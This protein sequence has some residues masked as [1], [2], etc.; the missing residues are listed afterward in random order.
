[1]DTD[2]KSLANEMVGWL[3]RCPPSVG[4]EASPDPTFL[5]KYA[6]HF[7]APRSLLVRQ[8]ML[9]SGI[10][11]EQE[12]AILDFGYLSGLTQEFIHRTFPKAKF[13]VYDHPD[14]PIFRDSNYLQTIKAM[15]Y[16]ELL[17]SDVT[18]IQEI[19]ES[20]DV[21]ILG[22]IIEHLDPT[23][24]ANLLKILRRAAKP[25]ALL[26]VTTPNA[27]GLYN[28][29]M[30]LTGKQRVQVAPIPD[31]VH[32]Y[33]HIHLW[34]P[35]LL[36]QTAQHYGWKPQ[37]VRFYH[38]RDGEMLDRIRNKWEGLK[39]YLLLRILEITTKKWPK[40]KG[41]FVSAYKAV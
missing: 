27:S 6:L 14:S 35:V 34:S 31:P 12:F 24:V 41:F 23:T 8:L 20:Y 4:L 37:A 13:T 5:Y 30:I 10:K 36:D 28:C 25:N 40:L 2:V 19:N 1:M 39:S 15:G 29:W 22:E 17:A 32:G 16:V 9:D 21:I 26:I 38:G 11:P 3:K 7:E 18:K 33:G